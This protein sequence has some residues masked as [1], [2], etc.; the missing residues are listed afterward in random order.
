[1]NMQLKSMATFNKIRLGGMS[2]DVE[3]YAIEIDTTGPRPRSFLWYVSMV[4]QK[5][6][7]QA[8][9]AGLVNSPPQSVVLY[10]EENEDTDVA[11]EEATALKSETKSILVQP[12]EGTRTGGWQF[13]KSQLA[14]SSAYQ[15]VLL[16]YTAFLAPPASR[17]GKGTP[18]QAKD[19]GEFLLLQPPA[20][21]A[22]LRKLTTTSLSPQQATEIALTEM[23]SLYYIR[24]NSLVNLPLHPRWTEK[25]W[26]RAL[27]NH[28]LER[29]HCAGVEAYLCRKPAEEQLRQEIS[30]MIRQGILTC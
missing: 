25:L 14:A 5:N 9:W 28:E 4:G 30:D 8:I 12:A 18:N 16:P 22:Y 17:K 13:I 20:L 15:G 21:T 7:V 6:A 2:A 11:E 19:T 1:M 23:Q 3:G 29:L 26:N 10:L 27:E 24:L